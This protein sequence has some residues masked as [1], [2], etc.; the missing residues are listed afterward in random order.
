[1]A[2]LTT[3]YDA[4]LK[5]K[6]FVLKGEEAYARSTDCILE[7]VLHDGER[8]ADW[9]TDI[10]KMK[11]E[12]H[13]DVLRDI[14]A[15]YVTLYDND[16]V[17]VAICW[18]FD[19]NGDKISLGIWGYNLADKKTIQYEKIPNISSNGVYLKETWN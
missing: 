3:T 15:S 9:N 8:R 12:F 1:M 18:V 11:L 5:E 13:I 17:I 19:K 10:K 6:I 7:E 2:K 4:T 14:G 16:D